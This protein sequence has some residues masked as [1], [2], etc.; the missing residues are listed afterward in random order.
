[1]NGCSYEELIP[2]VRDAIG[3]RYLSG[4]VI[5]SDSKNTKEKQDELKRLIF[6]RLNTG[7]ITLT[8]Q[9]IRNAVNTSKMNTMINDFADNNDTI[10]Q[11][12]AFWRR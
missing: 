8:K 9:E 7:G 10:Q 12:M 1:M 4:S 3:S 2:E 5:L 11:S 6:E